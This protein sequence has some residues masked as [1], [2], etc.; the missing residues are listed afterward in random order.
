M[1]EKHFLRVPHIAA[2]GH[3]TYDLVR[4]LHDEGQDPDHFQNAF[5]HVDRGLHRSSGGWLRT[6]GTAKKSLSTVHSHGAGN[7]EGGLMILDFTPERHAE[8]SGR[9]SWILRD[10]RAYWEYA[11]KGSGLPLSEDL[12][13]SDLVDEM[14]YVLLAYEDRARFQ[15]EFAGDA[16]SDLLGGNPIGATT[17]SNSQ[18]PSA[19]VQCIRACAERREP[20][21]ATGA[22]IRI[23]CL[24][25][26]AA[27]G[28]V[29]LVLAGLDDAPVSGDRGKVVTLVR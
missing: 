25:F 4:R 14:P 1:I 12:F 23:I 27:S 3:V 10:L 2:V 11:R 20:A 24:P 16:A 8:P 5:R 22:G 13:L 29:D 19:I 17:G 18:L 7:A 26:G 21:V 28:E 9:T 15:I 6:A